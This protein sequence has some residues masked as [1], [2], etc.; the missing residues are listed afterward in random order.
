LCG[1]TTGLPWFSAV[2]Y[3]RDLPRAHKTLFTV[4]V[5]RG[6]FVRLLEVA[7]DALNSKSGWRPASGFNH[8]KKACSTVF[9]LLTRKAI[10]PDRSD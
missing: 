7:A 8:R 1:F 5:R 3:S 10:V 9:V 4:V 6:A 2:R